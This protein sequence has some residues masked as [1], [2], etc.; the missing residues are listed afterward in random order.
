MES[1]RK[2]GN[3]TLESYDTGTILKQKNGNT[4]WSKQLKRNEKRYFLK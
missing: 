1:F 2:T 3:I 4:D